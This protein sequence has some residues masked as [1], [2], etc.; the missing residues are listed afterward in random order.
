IEALH[1]VWN[2]WNPF[3][4]KDTQRK[5]D[6]PIPAAK[7][8]LVWSNSR[9][10]WTENV[11][12]FDQEWPMFSPSVGKKRSGSRARLTYAEGSEAGRRQQGDPADL[13]AFMHWFEEKI[14][15]HELKVRDDRADEALGY[16]NMLSYR[17]DVNEQ[18]SE[19]VRIRLFQVRIDLPG[20]GVDA[21][22]W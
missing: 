11:G 8:L 5:L 6:G 16:C 18:G 15:D 10:A 17:Y 9:L 13:T 3:P 7:Y 20:P 12:G 19:L 14:L 21:H 1:A 2:F 22:A 4:G